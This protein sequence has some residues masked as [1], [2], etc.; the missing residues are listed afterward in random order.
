MHPFFS[1]IIATYNAAQT[2]EACL[3][4]LACQDFK[5]FEIIVADGLSTDRTMQIV[6]LFPTLNIRAFSEK[7]SGIYD[8][9]NKALKKSSGEWFYFLGADDTLWTNDVLAKVHDSLQNL[10]SQVTLWYAPVNYIYPATGLVRTFGLSWEQIEERFYER[11]CL[12]HQGVFHHHSLFKNLG[13]FDTTFRIAGDYDFILRALQAKAGIRFSSSPIIAGV[14]ATGVSNDPSKTLKVIAEFER[15]K[16]KNGLPPSSW[17]GLQ[18]TKFRASVV[19]FVGNQLGP[20]AVEHI[21][22]FLKSS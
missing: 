3:D 7:D 13:V 14:A 6:E 22:R 9:W 4:S 20:K 16:V 21:R 1:I 5:N 8:A 17:I 12:P 2:L 18:S 19:R 10:P 15:A 11:N